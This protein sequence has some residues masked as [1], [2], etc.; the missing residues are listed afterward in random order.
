MDLEIRRASLSEKLVLRHL[1]EL[2]QHDYSEYNGDEVDEHGLF[3]YDYLDNYWTE[4]E[5]HPFLVRVSGHLAGFVL[6][7]AVEPQ[8]K[9]AVHAIT[10]FFV[11][12]KY[13]RRG[14]GRQVA[15]QIFDRFPGQWSI[16]Q[17][18]DNGPAQSFWRQVIAEYTQGAYTEEHLQTEEWHGPRQ[19]FQSRGEN[20]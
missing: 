20:V 1:M 12:R 4:P 19:R 11:L 2:C 3:G 13:R 7:R 14:I 18:E 5:R 10:E 17:E 16:C 9:P 8:E 6:V 15:W